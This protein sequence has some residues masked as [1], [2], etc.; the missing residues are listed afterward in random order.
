MLESRRRRVLALVKQGLSLN[1]AARRLGCAPSSVMRWVQAH[2]R[3][4]D[5]GLKVL[6]ASGRPRRLTAR[7]E[8]RLL[9]ELLRGALAHGYGT[10]LWTT[11]RIAEVIERKFGGHYHRAHVSRLLAR[12]DWTPQKPE[13]RARERV[14]IAI[15]RWTRTRWPRVKGGLSNRG[16]TSSSSTNR[17]SCSRPRWFAPEHHAARHRASATPSATIRSR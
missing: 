17:G 1:A 14:E 10:E 16:P 15:A 8:A 9:R 13:R 6:Q 7:Q 3:H 5:A 2:H 4:G 12:N 11:K